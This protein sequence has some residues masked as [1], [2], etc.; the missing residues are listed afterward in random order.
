M[1]TDHVSSDFIFGTLATDARR[2]GTMKAELSGIAHRHRIEPIDPLPNQPVQLWVSLGPHVPADRVTCYFTTDG[3][4][5]DGERGVAAAGSQVAVFVRQAVRWETFLWGYLE[6]WVAEI[7]SQVVGTTVRYRIEAWSSLDVGSSWASEIIGSTPGD[8]TVLGDS[9]PGD[10]Y[11]HALGVEFGLTFVRRARTFAFRV[12]Q[13]ATPDWLYDGLIYQVFVD[14]YS[15]GGGRE[16]AQHDDLNAFYGG[17]LA[18][19]TEQ[20]DQIAALGTSIIWLSPIFP[21]PSHHGYD[22]TDFYAVEPRL[23]NLK[24]LRALLDAAHE[25]GIRVLLDFTANHVSD[26]HPAFQAAC[27]DPHSPTSGWFTFT[28][29]PETYISF[30]GVR[31]LPQIDTDHPEAR[32]ALIDAASFWLQQGVDGFRL[33]YNIGPSHAFWVDFRAAMRRIHPD[34]VLIGEAVETADLLRSY[35]GRLDGCLDFLLLQAL[36]L[37]FGFH[38][39]RASQFDSF[40]RRHL[41]AF[42]EGFVLPS[43]LDNHDMNRFLWIVGGDRRRL[44]LAALCQYT[45]PHPPILYYGTEVGL[46]QHQDVRHADGSGHPEESRLPMLWGKAQDQDLLVF[47]QH[48]G[49]LRQTTA[50]LWRGERHAVYLDDVAGHYAYQCRNGEQIG[51]VVLNN[52]PQAGRVPLPA[53]QWEIA[54]MSDTVTLEDGAAWLPGYSGAIL[55]ALSPPD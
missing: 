50:T 5:P 16:F 53:G 39:I 18:G 4:E 55:M 34:A 3:S 25:R 2:L 47:Y 26:Q 45:L 51:L 14:R 30:F 41:S 9:S 20:I 1:G 6:E 19:V 24:D 11:L 31:T 40:V 43:F 46:S 48:L 42:P 29:Y 49:H 44:K 38:E 17:T 52:G 32:Q 33:D 37:F 8:G 23:G 27:R 10:L 36:R 54:I 21:S 12:D 22:T 35:T 15:P 7:P 13:E 28:D